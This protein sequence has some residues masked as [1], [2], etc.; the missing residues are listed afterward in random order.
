MPILQAIQTFTRKLGQ[1]PLLG[2]DIGSSAIR[3]VQLKRAGDRWEVSAIGFTERASPSPSAAGAPNG[4]GA[5]GASLFGDRRFRGRG[6][7]VNLYPGRPIIRYIELPRMPDEELV[8]A[9]RWQAQKLIK[10]PLEQMVLDYLR[11][12]EFEAESGPRCGV[13]V[14]MAERSTVR[15]QCQGLART[16]LKV[17]AVDVTSLA[18]LNSIRLTHASDMEGAIAFAE[19]G[20]SKTEINVAIKGALRFTRTVATGG[21][22]ITS[23]IEQTSGVSAEEAETMKREV[24]LRETGMSERQPSD[25]RSDR[26]IWEIVQEAVKHEVDRCVLEIQRSLDYCRTQFRDHPVRKLV[27]M[28]G[29]PLMPGFVDYASAYFDVPVVL[30]DPFS[31]LNCGAIVTEQFR[32]MA[33]RFSACVGLALRGR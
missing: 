26:P 15:E 31:A 14:V 20:A 6:S 16:G 25:G 11:V 10:L 9:V 22:D 3:A 33:P 7:A 21:K 13:L 23:A 24:D 4:V 17:K 12:S 19:I 1:K 18:L 32:R 8:E 27:L 29:A 5:D 30:D 28:G 2:V